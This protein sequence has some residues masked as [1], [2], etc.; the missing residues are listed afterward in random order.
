MALLKFPFQKTSG[1]GWSSYLKWF[2]GE[3]IPC[4]CAQ[5]AWL[6]VNSRYSQVDNQEQPLHPCIKI[7]TYLHIY[8]LDLNFSLCACVYGEGQT[9]VY[10][11][12]HVKVKG[13]LNRSQFS[14]ATLKVLRLELGPS[15]LAATLLPKELP[16][17]LCKYCWHGTLVGFSFQG[18]AQ[19]QSLA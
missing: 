12:A 3:T 11:S 10:H 4:R 17:W 18:W 6:L 14:P 9:S 1:L 19:T 15:G 13:Q 8:Y 2:G 5:L 7:S 16:H